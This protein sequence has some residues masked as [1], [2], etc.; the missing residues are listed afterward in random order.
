MR[1][2]IVVRCIE[3]SFEVWESNFLSGKSNL[4][5]ASTSNGLSKME[6]RFFCKNLFS[7]TTYLPCALKS[8][9]FTLIEFYN[10]KRI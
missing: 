1:L 7:H 4:Q 5:V 8:P 3:G 10:L 9:H 6:P 2:L